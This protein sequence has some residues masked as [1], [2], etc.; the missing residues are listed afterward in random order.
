MVD[1]EPVVVLATPL[2]LETPPWI[3][4]RPVALRPRLSVGL[5]WFRTKNIC[6]LLRHHSASVPS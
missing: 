4:V 3:S 2:S 1:A 6:S 5:P